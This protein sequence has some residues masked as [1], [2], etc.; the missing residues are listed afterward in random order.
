LGRAACRPSSSPRQLAA[1]HVLSINRS[2]AADVDEVIV[3]DA[4]EIVGGA[5]FPT[6]SVASL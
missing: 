5:K 4:A 6:S 1:N 3:H 2:V